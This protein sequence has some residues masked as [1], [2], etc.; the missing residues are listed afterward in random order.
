MSNCTFTKPIVSSECI[1][2][3]LVKI[4]DN[5]ANLD[6]NLCQIQD[7]V[8]NL[9]NS[10]TNFAEGSELE[11]IQEQL[12]TAAQRT[13]QALNAANAA[14]QLEARLKKYI[15][16]A[17]VIP[18]VYSE[19]TFTYGKPNQNINVPGLTN[20]W[21]NVFTNPQRAPLQVSFRT[22]SLRT[23]ALVHAGVHVSLIN[24][25]SSMWTRV[26]N[27][28]D[29]QPVTYGSQEGHVSYSEGNTINMHRVIN[30]QPNKNYVFRVQTYI[31][32]T[33]GAV[34]INGW[35]LGGK[36]QSPQSQNNRPNITSYTP[37]YAESRSISNAVTMNLP[38]NPGAKNISYLQVI[39]I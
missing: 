35:H 34:T 24:R 11:A 8:F 17:I 33:A 1:G 21:A 18:A 29:N 27:V 30:L 14:K 16:D 38:G 37:I 15:N 10:L 13:Q 22:T 25:W 6:N 31:P 36:N 9:L 12:Q 20:T 4:N 23:K 28:T 2:D 39:L 32:Q 3:S 26:L 19:S 5:F 7:T